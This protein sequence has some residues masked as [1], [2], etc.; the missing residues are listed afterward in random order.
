MP[1]LQSSLVEDENRMGGRMVKSGKAALKLWMPLVI[2]LAFAPAFAHEGSLKPE[3]LTPQSEILAGEHSFSELFY[4]GMHIYT[5][6]LT[7]EDGLGEAPDGPRMRHL[8]LAGK[9]PSPF[10]RFNG[11]DAQSCFEC[12]SAVGFKHYGAKSM[13]REPGTIG[14]SAG[15]SANVF[16]FEQMNNLENGIVRNPPHQFGLGYIQR[17]AEEMSADLLAIRDAA[18]EEAIATG[19]VVRV[20]LES[21][22][23]SFGYF[24]T[25]A[26]GGMDFS[27]VEGVSMDLVVRPFQFKGIASTIRNFVS[28]AMNFHFSVQAKELVQRHLI[29][30][31]NPTGMLEGD[32]RYEFLEGDV[33]TL[34][35]FVSALRPPME[36]TEGL[37]EEAVARGRALMDTVGCTVCHIPSL[38]IN[39]PI[40]S[41]LDPDY[42]FDFAR[43]KMH[44]RDYVSFRERLEETLPAMVPSEPD[45]D[46]LHPVL[47]YNWSR[48][49]KATTPRPPG[50]HYN[51]NDQE[52]PDEAL[53]RLP[54]NSDGSIDVPLFSDLRRHRMGADLADTR[55]QPTD[56]Q[57]IVV[58]ADQFLTRPLWGVADT[59]P[60]L[61]DGR[62]TTLREAILF[63]AGEGSEA[64][65][66]VDA[67][68]ALSGEDQK[69][70]VE[71]LK[72]LRVRTMPHAAEPGI[73][74]RTGFILR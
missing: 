65:D 48:N 54:Y 42:V 72:S 24:T 39:D 71:F 21:K 41:I 29:L 31:D 16:I 22:G 13:P 32:V 5:N 26:V 8:S 9:T 66:S 7:T 56:M 58:P 11:L 30:D 73:R 59:G 33:T 64:N 61:H 28:G 62:A 55:T 44:T 63:H 46:L 19:A 68:R 23:V 69:A 18:I 60:W 12:H 25:F 51:L 70:L 74:H 47:L 1:P 40:L 35:I 6:R 37:D 10:L 49:K 3:V 57:S 45:S 15:F 36:S 2:S 34:S 14:G 27:E 50:Y 43:E 17:L 4:R 38:R 67:F 52:L 20:P 53:P